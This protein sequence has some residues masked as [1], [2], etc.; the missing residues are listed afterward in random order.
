MAAEIAGALLEAIDPW[1]AFL[2][3]GSLP[4][5]Q[6]NALA[7]LYPVYA[8]WILS[9]AH[10]EADHPAR[11]LLERMAA[12]AAPRSDDPDGNTE[13]WMLVSQLIRELERAGPDGF[14]ADQLRE[15]LSRVDRVERRTA[16]R[17]ELATRRAEEAERAQ[18]R[19]NE[20]RRHA[21]TLLDRIT[22]TRDLERRVSAFLRGPWQNVLTLECVRHGVDSEQA[23]SAVA[24]ANRLADA[25]D[26]GREDATLQV[27]LAERLTLVGFAAEEGE[28][29]VRQLWAEDT[30]EA[31]AA[32]GEGAAQPPPPSP[33]QEKPSNS[34]PKDHSMQPHPGPDEPA[35]PP[36]QQ[37][38]ESVPEP[39]AEAAPP[40]Q[41]PPAARINP[42]QLADQL[43]PGSWVEFSTEQGEPI[44]AKVSWKHPVT[45]RLL[46][47]NEQG[48]K[49]A[50]RNLQEIIDEI[51]RGEA[52]LLDSQ[53]A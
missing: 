1:F 27:E 32:G 25:V 8:R 17:A 3:G 45:R 12:I 7:S 21:R 47:V 23:H 33:D 36:R 10:V 44:R 26:T 16:R 15:R 20:S 4:Q 42:G 48:L 46:F 19:L 41:R 11:R 24:L 52:R 13:R 6:H 40:Q 39:T 34:P 43:V 28:Q 2:D 30:D 51:V 50:D 9:G 49:L 14:Q 18:K 5:A 37:Q 22:T 35:H 31:P 29:V 53:Q 38:R